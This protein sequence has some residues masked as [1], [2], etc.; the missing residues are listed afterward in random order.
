MRTRHGVAIT[1]LALAMGSGGGSLH[2]QETGQHVVDRGELEA[3]TAE[4][5]TPSE[6]QREAIRSV[7][8]RSAVQEVAED[9]GVDLERVEAAVA[10]LGG[11]ELRRVH[12]QAEKVEVAL[13][14]GD[15]TIV[16]SATTVIIILLVLILI[17]VA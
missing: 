6:A 16:I 10:A 14:G 3:A 8:E 9:H 7:L 15:D 1:V 4:A 17:A 11:E 5:T 2:A 13:A 12:A